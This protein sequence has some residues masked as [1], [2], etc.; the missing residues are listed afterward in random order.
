M[1]RKLQVIPTGYVDYGNVAGQL[2]KGYQYGR[3]IVQEEEERQRKVQELENQRALVANN[4]YKQN[5]ADLERFGTDLTTSEK[6]RF[7]NQ[8][9]EITAANREMQSFLLKGG[10]VNSPEYVA[11]QDG[12]EKLKKN[13]QMNIGALKEVKDAMSQGVALQRGKYDGYE[14]DMVKLSQAYNNILE[15]KYVPSTELPNKTTMTQKAYVAPSVVFE[16][17]VPKISVSNF[18]HVVKDTKNKIIKTEKKQVPVYSDL[19]TVAYDAVNAPAVNSTGIMKSFNSFKSNNQ[20]SISPDYK[21]RYDLYSMYMKDV[22]QTPKPITD[23]EPVDYVMMEMIARK[24][25][26][27]PDEQERFYKEAQPKK[28]TQSDKDAGIMN[29]YLS[30]MFSGDNAKATKVINTLSG[31]LK[32]KGWKVNVSG[33][34]I[35]ATKA[36]DEWSQ[37]AS[38]SFDLSDTPENRAAATAMINSYFS[39][40]G[41]AG[42]KQK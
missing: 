33:S 20:S 12:I 23:F 11:F 28:T 35:N 21:T 26:P 39:A 38:Y 16:S 32:T 27:A 37:G 8:F 24:Y 25:K 1:S 29:N 5:Q 31:A 6:Q 34:K 17:Y 15:G 42:R 18:D 3:N 14:D 19:E 7:L 22:K 13:L 41:S 40:I 10:K 36:A 4:I 30:D 2:M 9:D